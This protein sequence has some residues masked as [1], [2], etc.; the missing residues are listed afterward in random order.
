MSWIEGSW[1]LFCPFLSIVR[2]LSGTCV[3]TFYRLFFLALLS[4]KLFSDACLEM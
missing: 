2:G 4:F 3:Y 1:S